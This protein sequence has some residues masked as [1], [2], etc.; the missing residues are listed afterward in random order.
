MQICP[1]KKV[2]ELYSFIFA[3]FIGSR[4]HFF[5]DQK[6]PGPYFRLLPIRLK[7]CGIHPVTRIAP[8][9]AQLA[10]EIYVIDLV[11]TQTRKI[12]RY[13]KNPRRRSS[14]RYGGQE[15]FFAF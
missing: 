2:R 3:N 14:Q 6:K 1:G 9:L 10:R 7:K 11:N 5:Q 4:F 12:A 8:F 13:T 15:F